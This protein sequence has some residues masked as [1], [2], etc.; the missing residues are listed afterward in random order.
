MDETLI[1]IGSKSLKYHGDLTLLE[2]RKLY[3]LIHIYALHDDHFLVP[4]EFSEYF[5]IVLHIEQA[6]TGAFT[7]SI[8]LSIQKDLT[9]TAKQFALQVEWI[10]KLRSYDFNSDELKEQLKYFY[11]RIIETRYGVN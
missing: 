11:K 7:T 2:E 4:E 3:K 9:I 10:N 6:N 8:A 5:D 1:H